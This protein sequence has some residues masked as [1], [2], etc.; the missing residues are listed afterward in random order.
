MWT[1]YDRWRYANERIPDPDTFRTPLQLAA[2]MGHLI[3][4]KLLMEQYHC[5]DSLIAPDGQIALRLAAENGHREVVDYLPSRRGGG[6]RR[7]KHKNKTAI[8]RAKRAAAGIGTFVKFFVWDIEKFFLWSVPKH[9]IVKPLV[10]TSTWCWKHR[11]EF[12]PWCLRQTRELP[13]R[14]VELGTWI[15]KAVKGIAKWLWRVMLKIPKAIKDI[16]VWIWE[17]ITIRLAKAVILLAHWVGSG[18]SSV[19]KV[20]WN[21]ILKIVSFLS[22]VVTAIISFFRGL[23]LKDIWNGFCDALRAVFV[24]LPKL[25]WSWIMSFGDASYKMMKL[26]LGELGEILWYIGYG[27]WW[28]VM[29][30]PR[31][32]WIMLQ[33]FGSVIAKAGYEV[34][35]WMDPK[36]R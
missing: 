23:T 11:M 6:F 8:R 33:S 25:I 12:G 30:I 18:L 5:D 1:S 3:L 10:K 14:V 7:W 31:K 20:V 15:G 9:L 28:V 24:A 4:V 21:A 22:T 19:A 35:V 16:A 29:F 2:S 26:I 13:R 34:R 27:L 32:L 36:A 17:L